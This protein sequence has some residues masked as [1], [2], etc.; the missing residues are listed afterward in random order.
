[1]HK[2]GADNKTSHYKSWGGVFFPPF[3]IVSDSC[4]DPY[5]ILRGTKVISILRGAVAQTHLT[6]YSLNHSSELVEVERP[7]NTFWAIFSQYQLWLINWANQLICQP[8]RHNTKLKKLWQMQTEKSKYL[9]SVVG[10]KELC[11]DI[12]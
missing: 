1:M 5:I 2:S 10:Y 8:L 7:P 12:W 3:F 6:I 11:L 9:K 4:Q